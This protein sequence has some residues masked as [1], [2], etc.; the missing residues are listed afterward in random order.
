MFDPK[1]SL[2]IPYIKIPNKNY[3]ANVFHSQNI[4]TIYQIDFIK[5]GSNY[6]SCFIY[7]IWNNNIVTNN[8]Q[9]RIHSNNNARI[10]YNEPKYW[11]LK[12]NTSKSQI[13]GFNNLKMNFLLN[14]NLKLKQEMDNIKLDINYLLKC[15]ELN[16]TI[17]SLSSYECDSLNEYASSSD[18]FASPFKI[19]S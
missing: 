15:Q 5:T 17:E 12:K 3:I 9:E 14:E 19:N 18:D 13:K 16:E 1:L 7:L 6:Y 8:I 10:I 11:I 4:G 2:F